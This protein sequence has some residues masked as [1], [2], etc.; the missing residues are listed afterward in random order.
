MF[1]ILIVDDDLEVLDLLTQV[2]EKEHYQVSTVTD[3]DKMDKILERQ[4]FDV[5]LLD[6]MLPGRDGL[7]LCK[8][9]RQS[10]PEIAV[11]MIS[12]KG[13]DIDRIIGLEI[14]ADDYLPK[15]FNSRE[16]LARVKAVLRRKFPAKNEEK[17][18]IYFGD[19]CL[20]AKKLVVHHTVN[21]KQI[22]LT[23]G[24]FSLLHTLAKNLEKPISRERLLNETQGRDAT[25][26]DRSIDVMI[27]RLRQKI[28]E[29]PNK[30]SLLITIR[31]QGYVL[32]KNTGTHEG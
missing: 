18:E 8:C 26:Y 4:S 28:E 27:G 23:S 30:P 12:A 16:L 21:N 9:I 7:E 31:N 29:K 22:T 17:K 19:Y 15:P 6:I 1:S 13:E 5:I 10:H 20:N 2:L 24:E 25:P 32:L 3:G 11:I 14:G